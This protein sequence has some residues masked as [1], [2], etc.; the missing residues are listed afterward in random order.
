MSM[1]NKGEYCWALQNSIKPVSPLTDGAVWEHGGIQAAE[2]PIGQKAVESL[3]G[4][5]QLLQVECAKTHDR[6]SFTATGMDADSSDSIK[7]LKG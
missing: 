7:L 1:N 4:E 3:R 2:S 6:S 5:S